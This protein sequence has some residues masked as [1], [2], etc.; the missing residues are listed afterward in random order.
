MSCCW[1][2]HCL[3]TSVCLLELIVLCFKLPMEYFNFLPSRGPSLVLR[4]N[5]NKQ[6]KN[7]SKKPIIS[8]S[9]ILFLWWCVIGNHKHYISKAAFSPNYFRASFTKTKSQTSQSKISFQKPS[10]C[11][12]GAKLWIHG[13][14][15]V[16]TD[17]AP[18]RSPHHFSFSVQATERRDLL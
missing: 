14:F 8:I 6:M 12:K 3:D 5:Q 2:G 4:Y 7:G 11:E 18:T 15:T 1:G 10:V 16:E 17:S 9:E 13:R